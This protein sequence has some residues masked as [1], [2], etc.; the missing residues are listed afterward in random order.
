LSSCVV[1]FPPET[2]T[3]NKSQPEIASYQSIV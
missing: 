2:I 1:V 3:H